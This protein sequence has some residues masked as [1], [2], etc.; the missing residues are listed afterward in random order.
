V[1]T[2]ADER[3]DDLGTVEDDAAVEL[4]FASGMLCAWRCFIVCSPSRDAVVGDSRDTEADF[5]ASPLPRVVVS[6]VLC[7][8]YAVL[9]CFVL[10]AADFAELVS[11]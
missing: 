7:F 2:C 9:C 10:T 3:D 6:V 8:S 5:S 1:P 4:D 11:R